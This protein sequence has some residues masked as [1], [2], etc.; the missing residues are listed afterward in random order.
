[1]AKMI[2]YGED[3]RKKLQSGIDPDACFRFSCFAEHQRQNCCSDRN[4]IISP[5]HR[6]G[7]FIQHLSQRRFGPDSRNSPQH[8]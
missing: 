6:K 2:V 1:M 5:T 4:N 7:H 3:A 8:S